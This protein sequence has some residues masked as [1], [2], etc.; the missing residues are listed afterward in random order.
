MN[1]PDLSRFPIAKRL[2]WA[3]YCAGG[4][5][6][7]SQLPTNGQHCPEATEGGAICGW[8]LLIDGSCAWRCNHADVVDLDI[9]DAMIDAA[10]AAFPDELVHLV[11]PHVGV[12]IEAALRARED[13]S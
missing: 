7:I 3:R 9:T 12:A 10:L 1:N 6:P 4:A 11:A 8:P 5:V 2:A 13:S